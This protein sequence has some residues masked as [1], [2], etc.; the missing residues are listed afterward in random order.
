MAKKENNAVPLLIGAGLLLF[1]FSSKASQNDPGNSIITFSPGVGTDPT[2]IQPLNF[3]INQNNLFGVVGKSGKPHNGIDIMAPAGSVIVAP[4]GGTVKK[5]YNTPEAGNQL[6]ILHTNGQSTGYAHL[7][8]VLVK[9]GDA[10][11]Q[12][13]QVA[14]SGNTGTETTG[15]HLHF[16]LTDTSFTPINPI[17]AIYSLPA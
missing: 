9:E 11:T 3:P 1:A 2:W 10:L 7:Q 8:D 16:V 6:I 4:A 15:P 13:Q 12:G 14:H 5:V 17:P